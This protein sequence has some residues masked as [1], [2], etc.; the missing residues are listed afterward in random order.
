MHLTAVTTTR[1]I[2]NLRRIFNSKLTSEEID[3]ERRVGNPSS[4]SICEVHVH[5]DLGFW[6][7]L[8]ECSN[9]TQTWNVFGRIDERLDTTNLPLE[10]VCQ[11]NFAYEGASDYVGGLFARSRAGQYLVTHSGRLGGGHPG[12][13]KV[14]FLAFLA[15]EDPDLVPVEIVREDAKP[16]WR[17]VIGDLDA[18]NFRERIAHFVHLADSFK[19]A[20]RGLGPRDAPSIGGRTVLGQGRQP[21]PQVRRAIEERA[22]LVA[23]A[24]YRASGYTVERVTRQHGELDLRCVRR[25][26]ERRVEV[27][28]TAGPGA[29]VELTA[30]EVR[31][32]SEASPPVDL[33][34][35]ADISVD[36]GRSP[37]LA[38][39]GDLV[40]YPDFNPAKHA[41][42][43]TEYRCTLDRSLG[44]AISKPS[45]R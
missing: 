29:S 1:Q 19:R 42:V 45:R 31:R 44:R 22:M 41:A 30:A 7:V 11:I 34:V 14:P 2:K 25:G 10:H 13:G 3:S 16:T 38:T 33:A 35:V 32:A 36:A 15:R 40:V 21:D 20:V 4:T 18:P 27:K 43:P 6:V 9:D 12:V 26:A 24:Y 5:R 39:G 37:P 8:D 17:L 28:G 23:E